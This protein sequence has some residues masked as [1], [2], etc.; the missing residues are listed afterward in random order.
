MRT[1]K[2]KSIFAKTLPRTSE[3]FRVQFTQTV[4]TSLVSVEISSII[5]GHKNIWTSGLAV[6]IHWWQE[7]F[8]SESKICFT[9]T[10]L[11]AWKKTTKVC[12]RKLYWVETSTKT[13]TLYNISL[14][15]VMVCDYCTLIFNIWLFRHV[16]IACAA[17]S[18][19][20]ILHTKFSVF[21]SMLSQ[22]WYT[23]GMKQV[24]DKI[25]STLHGTLLSLKYFFVF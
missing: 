17:V 8:N 12:H 5:W 3:R 10:D 13:N 21:L 19:S 9:T 6:I 7:S 14:Y 24:K 11:I 15:K 23:C 4:I 20:K 1:N 25:L 16:I 18:K 2:S 22:L